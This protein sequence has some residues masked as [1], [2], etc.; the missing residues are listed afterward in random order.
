MRGQGQG[1]WGLSI[2]S[3]FLQVPRA[4]ALLP[5][6]SSPDSTLFLR[7]FLTLC[8]FP[9]Y[10]LT[11]HTP[12]T[13]LLNPNDPLRPTTYLLHTQPSSLTL[14]VP[15]A[16]SCQVSAMTPSCFLWQNR[17]VPSQDYYLFCLSPSF[18]LPVEAGCSFACSPVGGNRHKQNS[19]NFVALLKTTVSLMRGTDA[20]SSYLSWSCH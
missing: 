15:R 3:Q 6:V 18:P 7:F 14:C 10:P 11:S 2:W 1:S 4:N 9:N 13:P 19:G 5:P 20:P 17:L 12:L 8:L 16:V